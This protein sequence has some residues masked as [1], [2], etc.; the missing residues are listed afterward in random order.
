MILV[1]KK[2]IGEDVERYS[3][4]I[5]LEKTSS[6][7]SAVSNEALVTPAGVLS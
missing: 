5:H 7:V 6:F 4:K 3:G 2:V 1:N